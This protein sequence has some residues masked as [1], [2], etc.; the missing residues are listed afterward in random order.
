MLYSTQDHIK[1][2]LKFEM[3]LAIKK[4][5]GNLVD[6]WEQES[7][8]RFQEKAQ[9]FIDQYGNYTMAVR[10]VLLLIK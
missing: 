8:R 2:K 6:W 10:T 4:I 7:K 5:A 3:S 9:C 1:L